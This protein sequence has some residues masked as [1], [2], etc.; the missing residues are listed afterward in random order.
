MF[1][2]HFQLEL[3]WKSSPWAVYILL[4]DTCIMMNFMISSL[5]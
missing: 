4:Q 3:N 5:T 2:G 1:I